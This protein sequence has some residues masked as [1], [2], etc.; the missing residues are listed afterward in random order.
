VLSSTAK[1]IAAVG[2]ETVERQRLIRRLFALPGVEWLF[3]FAVG[4]R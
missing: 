3:P 1:R 4:S 2:P